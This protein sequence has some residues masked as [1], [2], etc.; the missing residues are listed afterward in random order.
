[1]PIELDDIQTGPPQ[2]VVL[3]TTIEGPPENVERVTR[4]A[5][6]QLLAVYRGQPGWCGALG[7]LGFGRRRSLVLSFWESEQALLEGGM[8]HAAEFRRRA[9]AAGVT[10]TGSERLEIV[11]DERVE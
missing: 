4:A 9:S 1:M 2:P 5:Q 6:G 11:F 3:I 8:A 10:I 7:L